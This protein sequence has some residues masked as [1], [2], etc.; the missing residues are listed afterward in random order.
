MSVETLFQCSFCPCVFCCQEDLD[1]HL[2]AWKSVPH[3]ELWRGVHF[4][5]REQFQ[6]G[7]DGGWHRRYERFV[8]RAMF[9]KCLV[10]LD[11][12]NAE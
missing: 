1:S 3:L 2:R 4:L 12:W 10:I 8:S 7:F 11:G 9:Q 5:L 6:F